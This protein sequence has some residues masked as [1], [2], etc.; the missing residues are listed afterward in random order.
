MDDIETER[1]ELESDLD[2]LD[3]YPFAMLGLVVRF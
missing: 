2:D 1:R 3:I